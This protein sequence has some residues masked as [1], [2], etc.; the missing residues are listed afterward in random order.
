MI[1]NGKGLLDQIKGS[2]SNYTSLTEEDIK[3]MFEDIQPKLDSAINRQFVMMTGRGYNRRNRNKTTGRYEK[4]SHYV[5][6]GIDYFDD[7][8]KEHAKKFLDEP[9]FE[10]VDPRIVNSN[11]Y[12]NE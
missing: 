10:R 1:N 8:M 5:K 2:S 12:D 4:G 6:G 3:K 9:E 11:E 7:A